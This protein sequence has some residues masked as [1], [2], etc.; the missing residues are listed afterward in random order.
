[1]YK[2]KLRNQIWCC[3]RKKKQYDITETM[4]NA[5]FIKTEIMSFRYPIF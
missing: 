1:M 2:N 3:I 5:N 4:T